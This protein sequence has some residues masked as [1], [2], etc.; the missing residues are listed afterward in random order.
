M[1]TITGITLFQ[2]DFCKKDYKR[3]HHC[4]KHENQ[5]FKNPKNFR[6]CFSC[7]QLTKE[8]VEVQFEGCGLYGEY[9]EFFETKEIL[10]CNHFGTFLHTPQNAIKGNAY[11][12]SEGNEEMPIQCAKFDSDSNNIIHEMDWLNKD[13]I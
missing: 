4:E 11:E 10:F 13:S 12:L 6:P 7:H 9:A 1:K 8:S 5:C 2:C 3:K